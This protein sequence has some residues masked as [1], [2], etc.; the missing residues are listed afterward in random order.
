[1]IDTVKVHVYFLIGRIVS[2]VEYMHGQARPLQTVVRCQY[3]IN[4]SPSL[5]LSEKE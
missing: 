2:E 3:I 1:M 5:N 4:V